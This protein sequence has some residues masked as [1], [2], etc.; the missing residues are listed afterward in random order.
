MPFRN[1]GQIVGFLYLENQAIAK[2]FSRDRLEI[3]QLFT[4]QAAISLENAQLDNS[5]EQQVQERTQEL[6]EK[7]LRLKQAIQELKRTQSQMIYT[8]K[9]SSLGQIV[10]G[11]AHEIN[12]PIGLIYGN[13]DG[14]G[15]R[16][17]TFN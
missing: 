10:A 11:I 9:M 16:V 14:F 6:H 12:N 2:A 4:A 8:E 1:R 7:N 5:L 3:L 17:G 15:H 13:I